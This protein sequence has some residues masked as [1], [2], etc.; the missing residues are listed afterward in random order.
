MKKVTH[1]K[2]HL[3]HNVSVG[4]FILNPSFQIDFCWETYSSVLNTKKNVFRFSLRRNFVSF[5]LY[6]PW[7]WLIIH[8][9]NEKI[10][11]FDIDNGKLRHISHYI[12]NIAQSYASFSNWKKRMYDILNIYTQCSFLF[13]MASQLYTDGLSKWKRN[14]TFSFFRRHTNNS[15]Y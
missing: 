7:E 13:I 15:T 5:L 12:S 10:L 6:V 3:L 1:L 14:S 8:D 11:K 4:I 2:G 9:Q